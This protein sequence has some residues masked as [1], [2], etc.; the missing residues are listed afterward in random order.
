MLQ[1]GKPLFRDPIRS[2]NFLIYLFLPAAL[3]PRVYSTS[4]I[5]EYQ[6][7][8]KTFGGVG[9]SQR[10]RLTTSSHKPTGLHRLVQG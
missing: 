2:L 5:N 4:N 7:Q 1:A 8:K 3:G 9:H 6:E 10:V